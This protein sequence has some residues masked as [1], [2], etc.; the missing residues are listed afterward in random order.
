ML[1]PVS[2]LHPD[3]YCYIYHSKWEPWTGVIIG[4]SRSKEVEEG[5]EKVRRVEREGGERARGRKTVRRQATVEEEVTEVCCKLYCAFFKSQ[6]ICQTT[7]SLNSYLFKIV[8]VRKMRLKGWEACRGWVASSGLLFVERVKMMTSV[9]MLLLNK[10]HSRALN[11]R[12]LYMAEVTMTFC[13]EVLPSS[14]SQRNQI[15]G[16]GKKVTRSTKRYEI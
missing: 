3:N 5:N 2:V 1:C 6:C 4:W 15:K 9:C 7:F 16:K 14:G 13:K 12:I 11:T 8:E 10:L